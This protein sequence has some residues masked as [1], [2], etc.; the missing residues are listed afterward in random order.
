[1]DRGRQAEKTA[2]EL[3]ALG[4]GSE[5]TTSV[6]ELTCSRSRQTLEN[7]R[8][9]PPNSREFGYGGGGDFGPLGKSAAAP[10][11]PN[12]SAVDQANYEDLRCRP[13]IANDQP[14]SCVGPFGPMALCFP[15]IRQARGRE[16]LT[17]AQR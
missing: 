1:M 13:K 7:L 6:Q 10:P 17:E 4:E 9:G 14:P 15:P 3:F 8:P 11:W 2:R 5:T 16:Y 12:G